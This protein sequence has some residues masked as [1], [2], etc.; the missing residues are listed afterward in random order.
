M[1]LFDYFFSDNK[2]CLYGKTAE[3]KDKFFNSLF[4]FAVKDK[5]FFQEQF[6][7]LLP[8][9]QQQF[10]DWLEKKQENMKKIKE[11]LDDIEKKWT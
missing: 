1:T 10:I 11:K 6:L 4:N 8:D 5:D 2:G 9:E 3:Q 7:D